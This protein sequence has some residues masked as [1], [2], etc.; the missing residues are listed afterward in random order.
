[1]Q[2]HRLR[3]YCNLPFLLPKF[4]S[5]IL[6][7]TLISYGMIPYENISNSKIFANAENPKLHAALFTVHEQAHTST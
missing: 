4:R 1:M 5:I 7:T 3:T 6:R 2:C